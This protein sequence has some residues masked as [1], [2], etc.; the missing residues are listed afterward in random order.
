MKKNRSKNT[1]T[2]NKETFL[3]LHVLLVLSLTLLETPL[4]ARGDRRCGFVDL[5]YKGLVWNASEGRDF[6]TI[7]HTDEPLL[8]F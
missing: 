6:A 7:E 3:L 2:A 8:A 5:G 1:P 4:V